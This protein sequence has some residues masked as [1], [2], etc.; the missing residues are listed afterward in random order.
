VSIRELSVGKKFPN[1]FNVVIEIP[2]DSVNKYEY[3]EE[4]DV[5]KLDRTLHSPLHYPVDYGFIPETRAED[6]DHTDVMVL[7]SYP[8]FPGCVMTVRPIAVMYMED[9]GEV[10]NKIVTVPAHNP[11]Y[12]TIK[13]LKDIRKHTQKEI[14]HFFEEYK[15][16]E[17]KHVVVAGWAGKNV[18]LKILK[19]TREV[20]QKEHEVN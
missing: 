20:Y 8:V 14:A 4:A 9:G 5:V 18:A 13:S 16:L 15:T 1:E 2:K 11:R 17:E 19:K 3:D 6:G 12:D 7:T 10:D